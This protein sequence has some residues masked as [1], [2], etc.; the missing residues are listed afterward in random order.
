MSK[1]GF[2]KKISKT[3]KSKK[4]HS[5]TCIIQAVDGKMRE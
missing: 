2:V 4:K 1:K 5:I 3:Y